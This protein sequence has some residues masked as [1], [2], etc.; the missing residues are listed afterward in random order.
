MALTTHASRSSKSETPY[1][2]DPEQTLKASKA[3]LEHLRKETERLQA[4][5]SK[6]D[7]LKTETSESEDEESIDDSTPIW[8]SLTTKQHIVDKNRLKPAKI[9]V[10]HALNTSSDLSICIISADPQQAVKN[11]VADDAFPT[12]LSTRITRIIGL[13]KLKARYKSFEQ[14]RA[15]RDEHD[16]FLADDRIVTRLPEVLG[17]TFYKSTSK[18]P[19]PIRIAEQNRVDGK[20]IKPEKNK[21][22]SDEDKF[23]AVANP[24]VVA[25][26]ITRAL[27]AV[28]VHLKPGTSVAVRVG[29][30]SFTAEQ[31]V[32]NISVVASGIIEHHVVKG[33]RNIK[34]IHI[35]SPT[36]TALPIWLANELWTDTADIYDDEELGVTSDS[37]GSKRKRNPESAKGPQA[38]QRKKAKVL[39]G[40]ANSEQARKQRLAAEKAKAFS[41]AAKAVMA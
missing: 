13:T 34:S 7:L 1:Q 6:K 23:A 20:R 29:L 15:L 30:T 28:P 27:S 26:E 18:R 21:K 41:T 10:P 33:W 3:L 14:K 8:L 2:L 38:G 12:D 17:K 32:D 31:L 40:E 22:K 16:I 24:A 35:K 9:T 39:S 4:T 37:Q 11:V 25:K 19:I 36:S 5:A